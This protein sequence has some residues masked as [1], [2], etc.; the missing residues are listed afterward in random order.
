MPLNINELFVDKSSLITGKQAQQ[1]H[2][3]VLRIKGV[4]A[5][6]ITNVSIPKYKMTV[7][8]YNILDYTINYPGKIEWQSPITFDVIQMLDDATI[9]SV[10]GY[11]MNKLY[12]SAYYAS[13][14][15]LGFGERDVVPI[16]EF[17]DKRDKA[18]ALFNNGLNTGYARQAGDGSILDLSKQ[19][20]T[21]A[22]GRVEINTL[23]TDGNIYDCWR[24]NGAF[25]SGITPADLTY[26][27]EKLS[28]V[29]VEVSYDYAS[30]GFRGVFA[31]EDAVVRILPIL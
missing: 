10:L 20:L 13:P 3:F 1:T 30:Y 23:D 24:L 16:K 4:D 19:K 9:T 27:E 12:N 15:G 21:A 11:F 25:I 14:T 22:L 5:A 29:K 28:T 18:A 7:A 2:R 17:Y 6:L 8:K 31:E 26:G